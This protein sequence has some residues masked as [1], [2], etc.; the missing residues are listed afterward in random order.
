M[1]YSYTQQ[2]ARG[3]RIRIV[4]HGVDRRGGGSTYSYV[5]VALYRDSE[6]FLLSNE[7][8]SNRAFG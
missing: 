7:L 5:C 4:R 3:R 2:L 1:A 8:F 6:I